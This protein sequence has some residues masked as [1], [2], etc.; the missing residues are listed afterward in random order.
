VLASSVSERRQGKPAQQQTL[1]RAPTGESG[2]D[3]EHAADRQT[4]TVGLASA[5]TCE[6]PFADMAGKVTQELIE[7]GVVRV[8]KVA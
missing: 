4:A 1:D 8:K 6:H 7:D 2:H 3:I 5:M